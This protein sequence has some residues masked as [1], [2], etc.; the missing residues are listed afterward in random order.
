[1]IVAQVPKNE[2]YL[3]LMYTCTQKNMFTL[4]RDNDHNEQYYSPTYKPKTK[5]WF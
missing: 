2:Y 4:N 3:Y 1:M 5:W